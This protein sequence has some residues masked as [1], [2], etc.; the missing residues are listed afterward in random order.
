MISTWTPKAEQQPHSAGPRSNLICVA[1]FREEV[2]CPGERKQHECFPVS[3]APQLLHP[4]VP[5][6]TVFW[7]PRTDSR[8]VVVVAKDHH[9]HQ[10]QFRKLRGTTD[11]IR[12][13]PMLGVNKTDKMITKSF[14]YFS[15]WKPSN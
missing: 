15:F 9:H 11:W 1:C 14:S 7:F 10:G 4:G 3:R 12:I 13:L 8:H 2:S 5:N 6:A